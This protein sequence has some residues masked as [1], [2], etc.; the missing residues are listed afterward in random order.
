MPVPSPMAVLSAVCP[1]SS[2]AG[3]HCI[4]LPFWTK[5]QNPARPT[6]QAGKKHTYVR[7]SFS[8]A[9]RCSCIMMRLVATHP[10]QTCARCLHRFAAAAH[11][12]VGALPIKR[13]HC[14]TASRECQP[15][16]FEDFVNLH[17][18]AGRSRAPLRRSQA[19]AIKQTTTD[20]SE[21]AAAAQPMGS[22]VSGNSRDMR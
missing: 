19:I 5:K 6:G 20:S 3:V 17:T 4:H 11:I 7:L 8:S 21:P 2:T 18:A 9:G 1:S 10:V 12:P 13:L 14:I 16:L 15:D 22:S